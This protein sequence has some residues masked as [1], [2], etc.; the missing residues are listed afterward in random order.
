MADE[1]I[2]EMIAQSNA[3]LAATLAGALQ[4]LRAPPVPTM[5]LDKFMGYPRRVG[6]PTVAEWLHEFDVYARQAGVQNADR[7]MAILDHLGGCAREEVLCHPDA[8]RHDYKALVTLLQLRFGPPET[9]PSLSTA[10]HARMQLDGETLADY[11]RVLMRLHSRMEKAA[12]TEAEGQALA[13]LRDNALKE[14]FVRGVREQSVR[15]ELRRIALNSI[16]KS[17]HH[18]R[19]EALYL[20]REHDERHRTMRVRGAEVDQDEYLVDQ[21]SVPR[22]RERDPVATDPLVSQML[23][24]QQQLQAQMMQLM[25]QQNQT[26]NQLQAV[27]DRLPSDRAVRPRFGPSTRP[28]PRDSSCFFCRE[29][30]HFI[31]DCPR[32]RDAGARRGPEQGSTRPMASSEN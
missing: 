10:F 19:D 3:V 17:F 15:Q 11:S 2:A 14:Q 22:R 7:A 21:V 6:D 20:L 4:G 26:A 16:N 1:R 25:A 31:R 23:K 27:L 8:V 30:G 24:T 9:V 12:T 29:Q 18:M 28:N 32:K 13:L 5:K